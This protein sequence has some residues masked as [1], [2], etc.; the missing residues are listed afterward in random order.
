M[1]SFFLLAVAAL[2]APSRLVG[3][4]SFDPVIRRGA[5]ENPFANGSESSRGSSQGFGAPQEAFYLI[6]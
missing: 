5:T 3:G 4:V 6:C 1:Q 2:V